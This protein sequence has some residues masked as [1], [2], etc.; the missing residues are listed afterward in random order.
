M[1][2]ALLLPAP[3]TAEDIGS[4]IVSRIEQKALGVQSYKANFDLWLRA[5]GE[6]FFLTGVTL[7]KWPKMLRTEM[8]LR[9]SKELS[10]VIYWKGGIVWQYLP[11]ARI[12]F[13]QQEE[14]L[15]GKYPDAFASQDLVNLQNPFDLIETKTLRFIDE[16]RVDG[17][18]MYLFEGVP[19][20]AI[21]HQGVLTPAL[22]RMRIADENGLLQDLV[23]YDASGQEVLKQ[24]FWDIQPNLELLEEEFEFRPEN[25]KLVE[26]TQETEKKMRLMLKEDPSP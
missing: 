3:A 6:E 24:H 8:S 12:A 17:K 7:F 5:G 21:R 18:T 25:A 13:R 23:L 22:C 16:E 9:G 4:H 20:K 15:R 2:G 1:M 14:I 19:K 26:I 10:Q 11:S